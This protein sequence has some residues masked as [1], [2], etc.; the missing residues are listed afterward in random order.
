MTDD[1]LTCPVCLEIDTP[2]YQ[3]RNGHI[4]CGGCLDRL[5]V[6][7]ERFRCCPTCR[8]AYGRDRI[9]CLVA[10][11]FIE[12]RRL[13][14]EH[15][16]GGAAAPAVVSGAISSQQQASQAA[17]TVR[18][19]RRA[20]R[21][22]RVYQIV[23][24]VID[25]V[26][27][28]DGPSLAT[29]SERRKKRLPYGSYVQITE[30][31]TIE[32]E[33][34]TES[35]VS[36]NGNNSN[37]SN[38]NGN[39]RST[40]RRRGLV[41]GR[42]DAALGEGWISIRETGTSGKVFALQIEPATYMITAPSVSVTS[43]MTLDS[44]RLPGVDGSIRAGE[45]VD[46]VTLHH[47][48]KQGDR[49]R[50]KLATGGW[51][52]LLD[53][54]NGRAL[55][56][57]FR[58]GVYCTIAKSTEITTS[59]RR[60]VVGMRRVEAGQCLNIT[61]TVYDAEDG[62]VRGHI[63]ATSGGGYVSLMDKTDWRIHVQHLPL[64]AYQVQQAHGETLLSV[65]NSADGASTVSG[66]GSTTGRLKSV[67][68]GS[69]V[70]IV[71]TTYIDK[72][73][74]VRGRLLSGGWVNLLDTVA[75]II[76]ATPVPLGVYITTD[77]S[78]VVETRPAVADTSASGDDGEQNEAAA[79]G[80]SEQHA[81]NN[82]NQMVRKLKQYAAF[83]VTECHFLKA[84]KTVRARLATGGFITLV[85]AEGG[86]AKPIMVGAWHTTRDYSVVHR[87]VKIEKGAEVQR[88][89]AE[90]IVE[91]VETRYLERDG[92]IRGRLASGGWMSLVNVKENVGYAKQV[93]R[94][95]SLV[96]TSAVDSRYDNGT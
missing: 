28:H 26:Y 31:I 74:I 21:V 55:A 86:R 58:C 25:G 67:P 16:D 20:E 83:E 90:T 33:E 70:E 14:S 82:D 76:Y 39:A 42:I 34:A 88:I 87:S 30:V 7:P 78:I 18:V 50:G 71:Q 40:R 95:R 6:Q 43:G 17:A 65:H 41:R 96:S 8:V 27:I 13:E 4:V 62:C 10:E 37:N 93:E 92:H 72:E 56:C 48:P 2:S 60:E 84:Q 59:V 57:P 5:T 46:I 51:I 38:G 47:M 45:C 1:I 69:Y 52:T 66:V 77:E 75:G 61:N 12:S 9:R 24:D 64:G 81:A 91:I 22:S 15:G 49:V 35:V 19:L 53:G 85:N 73:S 11:A 23:A 29:T 36:N 89:P 63:K 80:A 54:L 94:R 3:C 68:A 32:V 44:A 79:N